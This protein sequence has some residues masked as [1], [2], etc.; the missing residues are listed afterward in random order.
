[1]K[2]TRAT[3]PARLAKR[4]ISTLRDIAAIRIIWFHETGNAV[5][6]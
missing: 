1:M 4:S 3:L 6:V 2:A 5:E